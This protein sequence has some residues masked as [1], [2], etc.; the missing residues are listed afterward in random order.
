MYRTDTTNKNK[1]INYNKKMKKCP[2]CK[3]NMIEKR[4]KTPDGISYEY[5]K[6]PKCKEEIV[7]MKQLHEVAR[8]YRIM[9][10]YHVKLTKWGLSYGL[11]I[12]QD[13]IKRDK[14]SKNKNLIIIPEE[15]GFRVIPEI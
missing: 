6:C 15:V 13:I 11:R 10:K 14:L 2:E 4:S 12:P 7:D 1:N 3:A 5:F 8:K 9:K